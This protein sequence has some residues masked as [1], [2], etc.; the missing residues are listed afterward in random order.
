[1]ISDVFKSRIKSPNSKL[2]SFGEGSIALATPVG[3]YNSIN[4][5]SFFGC[6]VSYLGDCFKDFLIEKRAE[7]SYYKK[8]NMPVI[9][10]LVVDFFKWIVSK[11]NKYST[12]V[13]FAKTYIEAY[14]KNQIIV[15]DSNEVKVITLLK[16][17]LAVLLKRRDSI[18]KQISIVEQQ[19]EFLLD[20]KS[21]GGADR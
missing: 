4:V 9:D 11:D 12:F 8:N 10:V 18:N 6:D 15:D 3:K 20:N 7:I 2:L 19:I 5:T 21:K 14:N 17:E 13:P 1:M 16:D